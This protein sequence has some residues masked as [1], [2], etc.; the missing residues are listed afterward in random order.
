MP[1]DDVSGLT[2]ISAPRHSFQSREIQTQSRRSV[3]VTRSRRARPL[4]HVELVPQREHLQ[5]QGDA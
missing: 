2:M 5:L 3:R 4:Q 1:G